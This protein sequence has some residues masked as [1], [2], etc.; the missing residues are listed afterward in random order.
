MNKKITISR[1]KTLLKKRGWTQKELC[2]KSNVSQQTI[3]HI[4]K[5]KNKTCKQGVVDDIAQ[6]LDV[7]PEYLTNETNYPNIDAWNNLIGYDMNEFSLNDFLGLMSESQDLSYNPDTSIEYAKI[8]DDKNNKEYLISKR[9]AYFLINAFI[10]A[11]NSFLLPLSVV[12]IHDVI[13]KQYN[14][15]NEKMC[16]IP[17][18]LYFKIHQRINACNIYPEYAGF[19]KYTN[20]NDFITDAIKEKIE[21]IEN[22]NKKH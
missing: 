4:M 11:F 15:K 18:S 10:G 3:S 13:E 19:Q 14:E 6:A 17:E 20:V 1:L 8:I 16:F 2:E 5:D 9:H 7:F 22:E 12:N 21:M